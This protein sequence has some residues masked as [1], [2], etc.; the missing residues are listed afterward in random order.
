MLVFAPMAMRMRMHQSIGVNVPVCVQETGAL[1]QRFVAQDGVDGLIRRDRSL[2]EDDAA[3]GDVLDDR[4][5]V[6]RGDDGAA[7]LR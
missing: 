1:Q 3:V 5:V 4:K 7:A 6:C 2:V